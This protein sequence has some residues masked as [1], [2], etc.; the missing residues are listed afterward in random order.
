[1]GSPK[2][3]QSGLLVA[4]VVMVMIPWASLLLLSFATSTC[5]AAYFQGGAGVGDL[6][7]KRGNFIIHSSA[8]G[9]PRYTSLVRRNFLR[10]GK[11]SGTFPPLPSSLEG[12]RGGEEED[13]EKLP[14][15]EEGEEQEHFEGEQE[16]PF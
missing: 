5:Q 1:M 13:G 8:N 2:S 7:N 15:E 14:F 12:E 16:E 11:R 3:H 10:F 6:L 4:Q 9:K